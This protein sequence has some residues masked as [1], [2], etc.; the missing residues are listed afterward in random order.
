VQQAAA[1]REEPERT[2]QQ[3]STFCHLVNSILEWTL[4]ETAQDIRTCLPSL[5]DRDRRLFAAASALAASPDALD[6]NSATFVA[7]VCVPSALRC[8]ERGGGR[9]G[10]V[11]VHIAAEHQ[12]KLMQLVVQSVRALLAL[13]PLHLAHVAIPD[14]LLCRASILKQQVLQLAEN[15]GIAR[16]MLAPSLEAV[17]SLSAYLRSS[18]FL[19]DDGVVVVAA[20]S[21]AAGAKPVTAAPCTAWLQDT[22]RLQRLFAGFTVRVSLLAD[23]GLQASDLPGL[24]LHSPPF[25]VEPPPPVAHHVIAAASTVGKLDAPEFGFALVLPRRTAGASAPAPT[26]TAVFDVIPAAST[27]AAQGLNVGVSASDIERISYDAFRVLACLVRSKA[28]RKARAAKAAQAQPS[29][30]SSSQ[31]TVVTKPAFSYNAFKSFL[32]TDF[33]LLR[34]VSLLLAK[35]AAA[36]AAVAPASQSQPASS[37]PVVAVPVAPATATAT[38][39]AATAAQPAAVPAKN[40]A[41]SAS[42][43]DFARHAAEHKQSG[44][45]LLALMDG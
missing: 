17:A 43:D 22:Q 44:D 25:V 34:P 36:S 14:L 3:V 10:R 35:A 24:T 32:S 26:P 33:V 40:V 1:E 37:S 38:P 4:L 29:S 6:A 19:D 11:I 45:F 23:L 8:I 5:D 7:S 31:P 27:T 21:S 30:S 12:T 41:A 20:A 39:V 2:Q 42:S 18:H 9:G 13:V 16:D 28:E 15:K